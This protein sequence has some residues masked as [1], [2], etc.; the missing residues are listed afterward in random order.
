MLYLR[1]DQAHSHFRIE[2]L[3]AE[4]TY[5]VPQVNYLQ[6]E[7]IHFLDLSSE[8]TDHQNKILH[9][10]LDYGAYPENSPHYHKQEYPKGT[11]ILV[12]PR[13][14]T[15]SPWSSKATDIIHHCGLT[16]I[17][18]IER[19]IAYYVEASERLT[20]GDIQA[21]SKLLYDRMTE[22]V[23]YH[24][25]EAVSLFQVRPKKPLVWIDV[26]HGDINN[27]L[28]ANQSLGLSLDEEELEYLFNS[29]RAQN[30]NPS[31]AE[32][33]MFAQLNSEH[34]R[35][36][37]FKSQWIID[38]VLRTQSL[39]SM[40]KNTTRTSPRGVLSA[41]H[42]NAAVI[43]GNL[44]TL[45]F[46]KP[47][48]HYEF[49]EEPIH[50]VM[51]VETCNHPTAISPQPGA[52][53][54]VG[55]E[56]RDEAAVGRGAKSKAGLTGFVVSNLRIPEYTHPWEISHGA[57]N[58]VATPLDIILNAPLGA[59]QFSNE[60]GRPNICG[61]FRTFEQAVE[62]GN[63]IELR[64]FHKPILL[65]GGMGNIRLES[66][67]KQPLEE[68]FLVLVLGGPAMLI[69]LGGS[70]A[71]SSV[72]AGTADESLDFASVHRGNPEMQQRAQQVI[73]SCT[74]LGEQ[75]PILAIHDVGAGGLANAIPELIHQFN[76]GGYFEMSLI[77]T[78]DPSMSPLEL[79]CNEAQE[80]FVLA[81][82]EEQLEN[83]EYF[84]ARENCPFSIIGKVIVNPILQCHDD[85][86]SKVYPID[87]PLSLL[88]DGPIMRRLQINSH[89]PKRKPFNLE[90]IDIFDAAFRLL[91]LPTIADKSFLITICDR[92]I[93]GLV[94]RDQMVGPWQVP[95]A[96]CA[97]TAASFEGFFGEAMSMGERPPLALIDARASARMAVGEAI[98]N[99]AAAN[100]GTLSDVR[101]SANWMAACNYKNEEFYLYEAVKTLGMEFCPALNLAI[102]VGKDS[103]SMQTMWMDD[104][105]G[106]EKCMAAPLSVVITAFAPVMDIRRTLTPEL[107]CDTE[108][109]LVYI[110]LSNGNQRLGGS[111]L[112]Y[113]YSALGDSCPDVD[114]PE[115]LKSFF[116]AI[117]QLNLED[118]ILAYHDRSDGGLFITLCEMAFASHT[119]LVL[120]LSSIG[121]H[122]LPILF[123]EE[124]GA[125]IQVRIEDLDGVLLL[126]NDH[127]LMDCHPI[128]TIDTKDVITFYHEEEVVFSADRV[129]LQLAWSETSYHIQKLRDNPRTAKKIY[130]TLNDRDDPGLC[131][132]LTFD[133]SDDITAPFIASGIR[134]KI[135]IL[136][137]QGIAGQTEMAAAFYRA[138]FDTI[139]VH[140]NDIKSKEISLASVQALAVCGGFSFGDALGAGQGFAKRIIYDEHLREEFETFFNRKDT[141]TVGMC[142][143]CQMLAALKT[144]IPGA[145][146]WPKFM[147]NQSEQFEG[148]LS[149]VEVEPSPSIL[150]M[151]MEG[152]R[153]IVPVAHAEGLAEFQSEEMQKKLV[154]KELVTLRFV[155]S[156]GRK[157]KIYPANP[158]GS[159]LGITGLTTPDGRVTIMMPNPERAF[160]TVQ[161]SWHPNHWGEDAPWLR[162]FRNGRLWL[163]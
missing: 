64:G 30:R 133:P 19:G 92:T 15:V 105:T 49:H 116:T 39:F 70:G 41:Y 76:R 152:S 24:F 157:T 100:I 43:A 36:R 145:E 52:A 123:N 127:G 27:L 1:G 55:G 47:D 99:I 44:S 142:N 46:P 66:I 75:N 106:E 107:K 158:N 59:A 50:I 154:Q 56:I 125:V 62:D 128:G 87:T 93:G 37:I 120:D 118:K 89:Q 22:Q 73:N 35:H 51:K 3:L 101:L 20:W 53:T 115:L 57:P 77:P 10:L 40:I 109:Q 82:S 33:M 42:D 136:R 155:D 79:W 5:Q 102:P 78:A 119:G 147:R 81:V 121:H 140:T 12:V 68:G 23:F 161:Y 2:G 74:S 139:D 11:L 95:V 32:L 45:F 134:P 117:Q 96:D 69:G 34:C 104:Q 110:D 8:L 135:A 86:E 130:E 71:A 148:R 25:E 129:E 31:D 4:I 18:R 143:G 58:R 114:N 131:S 91:R 80:R 84:A 149:I 111:A 28:L 113:V 159:P 153:L 156:R 141:F 163:G 144:L 9:H 151:G 90:E 6:A 122:P 13:V 160:R 65:A 124:L 29:Y 150:F 85:N 126:L 54:G 138:G 21:I 67:H 61:Y 17:K 146:L 103:L 94:N 72:V 16:N 162:M 7:F 26:L 108:T 137:E 98:T 48:H 132:D 14:G 97:V 38:G 63:E 88:F 112:S 83:F 60:F